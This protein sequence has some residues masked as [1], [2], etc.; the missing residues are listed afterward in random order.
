MSSHSR[1][2]LLS[3]GKREQGVPGN[4]CNVLLVRNRVAHWPGLNRT[5]QSPVPK[6]LARASIECIELS[7]HW[8]PLGTLA[9]D[10]REQEVRRCR[11]RTRLEDR[12]ILPELPLSLARA[13]IERPYRAEARVR[14]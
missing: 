10:A 6:T 14:R 1:E 11:Q 7:V 2:N 5:R 13:R 4:H 9:E 3:Q 12:V 8:S